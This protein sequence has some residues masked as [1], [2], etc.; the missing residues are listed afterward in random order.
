MSANI[1]ITKETETFDNVSGKYEY[2][3]SLPNK[4][5]TKEEAS[6]IIKEHTLN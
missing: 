5:L 6:K 1:Q 3:F 4:N 2:I